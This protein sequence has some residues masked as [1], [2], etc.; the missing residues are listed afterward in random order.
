MR[1]PLL[2]I[3]DPITRDPGATSTGTDSP[4]IKELSTELVPE[5][6][7]PSV[8]I[9]EPGLTTNSSPTINWEIGRITSA[10]AKR[11][12]LSHQ[13]QGEMRAHYLHVALREIQGN[14]QG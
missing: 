11:R 3:A 13:E 1:R 9:R 14:D 6:I 12:L 8:A 4:V 7:T 10:L 2:F 5:I